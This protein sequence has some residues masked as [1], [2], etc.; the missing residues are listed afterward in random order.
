[1]KYGHETARKTAEREKAHQETQGNRQKE[2]VARRHKPST[3]QLQINEKMRRKRAVEEAQQRKATLKYIIEKAAK[4]S[5]DFVK[6]LA[7]EGLTLFTDSKKDL[8]VKM[9]VSDGKER[10]YSLQKDLAI[11]LSILPSI[12][13]RESK[14]ALTSTSKS[15]S[16]SRGSSKVKDT[17]TENSRNAEYEICDGKSADDLD[18]EWKRRNGYKQ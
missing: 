17:P 7:A 13:P 1:M 4:E 3:S 15:K 12:P 18:E 6:A 8:Y 11:D 14:P 16:H 10:R 5:P 9:T 2:R